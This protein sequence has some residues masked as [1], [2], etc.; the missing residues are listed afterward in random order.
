MYCS[1]KSKRSNFY[2]M[3][4]HNLLTSWGHNTSNLGSGIGAMLRRFKLNS[5]I[6]ILPIDISKVPYVDYRAATG[7]SPLYKL[8]NR[9][10]YL[11]IARLLHN[12]SAMISSPRRVGLVDHRYPRCQVC[13]SNLRYFGDLYLSIKYFLV[14]RCFDNQL[15]PL[16]LTML[17]P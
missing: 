6:Y 12:R 13:M 11:R 17:L 9:V 1:L 2:S 8:Y 4:L 10:L 7:A 15:P 5:S 16:I 14:F 3:H